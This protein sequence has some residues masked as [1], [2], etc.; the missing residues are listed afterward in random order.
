MELKFSQVK[1]LLSVNVNRS[2]IH[3]LKS[4][5]RISKRNYIYWLLLNYNKEDALIE[6]RKRTPG[7]LEYYMYYKNLPQLEAEE[8]LKQFHNT[9]S[10]TK[11][12]M[13]SRYGEEEG[14]KRWKSYCDK[15]AETNTFE[16]KKKK[17]GWD[18]QQ[19]KEFNDSRAVTK[20]NLVKRHGVEKGTEKWNVYVERQRYAGCS[21]DYFIEKHGKEEGTDIYNILVE[22]RLKGYINSRRYSKIATSFFNE[23]VTKFYTNTNGIWC[24]ITSKHEYLVK[25]NYEGFTKS[26]FYDF[27]DESKGK[28]IEFNGDYWH[29]NPNKYK[30]ND[31]V[32][33]VKAKDIWIRDKHKIDYAKGLSHINGVLIVW[34]SDY[35]KNPEQVFETCKQFL[36]N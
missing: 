34:E 22:K 21:I 32:N 7:T 19:F 33:G 23:I 30:E 29:A 13:I 4:V 25:I 28:I 35:K 6:S 27:Y 1:Q 31:I 16:Y 14:N 10:V 3:K 36:N 26:Y 20:D 11:V 24:N 2:D 9:K 15:Q 17:Y 8:Q 5:T 18:E 12:N